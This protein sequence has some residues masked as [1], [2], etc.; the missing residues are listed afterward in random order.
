MPLVAAALIAV[1]TLAIGAGTGSASR[2]SAAGRRRP[3]KVAL[4]TD[5]GGLDDRSFN[6]LAN[7]GLT[8][9]KKQLGVEGR[10][11]ISKSD[12]RLRPEPDDRGARGQ[13]PRDRRRLPDGGR[14]RAGREA[15][16]E[17]EVR[18][19]RL[20]RR[21]RARRASPTNVRGLL[22]KEQEAGYLVGYLAARQIDEPAER[23]GMHRGGRR[24]EDPAG[25]PRSSPGTTP[26]AKKADA[27]RQGRAQLLPG[28]RRPG[29]VQ[30]AGA[31]TRSPT[32]PASSSRSRASAASA[33]SRRPRRRVLGIG[34]DADQGY[35]G[36]HVLTS[37]HEEG[38]RGRV[39]DDPGREGRAR[40]SARTSTRSSP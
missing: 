16:P 33:S 24:P 5:I 20:Q 34:V 6:F 22:F 38:R 39:Q 27:G 2:T 28:L 9:A 4:V 8:Q 40:P 29:E 17:D 18:D 30:G 15:V 23:R 10:V 13:Q 31:R 21:R 37:A 36:P 11:F 35:L 32:V 19:H 1:L 12:A 7:K 25:R 14:D 26:G 3:F